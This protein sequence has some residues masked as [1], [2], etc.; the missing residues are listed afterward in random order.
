MYVME[1]VWCSLRSPSFSW[2]QTDV[3]SLLGNLIFKPVFHGGCVL[4][5]HFYNEFLC[6]LWQIPEELSEE[7]DWLF[8]QTLYSKG[9]NPT[10][11]QLTLHTQWGMV[12][13][14]RYPH[15]SWCDIGWW[16][17]LVEAVLWSWSR[18][19]VRRHFNAEGASTEGSAWH[20]C[21]FGHVRSM[22]EM[23]IRGRPNF[24]YI[25]VH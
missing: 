9:A 24:K 18:V 5:I 21:S 14:S 11:F 3:P 25:H 12:W 23:I 13:F 19:S 16:C 7:R 15:H 17:V 10:Q 6:L 4:W 20:T 22:P 8:M 1:W 2:K